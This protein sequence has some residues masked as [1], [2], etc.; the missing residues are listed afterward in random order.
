VDYDEALAELDR[1]INREAI[2]GRIEGLTVEPMVALMEVLGDPHLA[3]PV[4]HVTGTNGKGSTARMITALLAEH[5]LTVGT[6][7]SPHLE[8]VNERIGRNGEPIADDELAAVISELVDLARWPGSPR[9]TSS[10]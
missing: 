9:P 10:C 3:Y 8:R 4:I 5:G 1:H 7:A 6:Y 2:A